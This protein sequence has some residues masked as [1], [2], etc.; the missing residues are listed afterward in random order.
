MYEIAFVMNNLQMKTSGK[1]K[2]IRSALVYFEQC[3]KSN[4]VKTAVLWK[5]DKAAI[6]FEAEKSQL[7]I[8]DFSESI[9][10]YELGCIYKIIRER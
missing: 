5:D 9:L 8:Y 10:C 1:L 4:D 6:G 3:L 7:Y 2:D